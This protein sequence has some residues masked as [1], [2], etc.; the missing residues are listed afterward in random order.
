MITVTTK[1]EGNWLGL[2]RDLALLP[3]AL[4][5]SALW[6]QRKWGEKL[7][8]ILRGH[9]INQDLGWKE[10]KANHKAGDDRTLIDTETYLNSIKTWQK[11]FV[12]Y[13]G[14][15]RSAREPNGVSTEMVAAIHEYKSY[16]GGPYRALWSPSIEELGGVGAVREFVYLAILNKV[17]KMPELGK[18]IIPIK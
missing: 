14:V 3:P 5:S 18:Y 4:K 6:G 17:A 1:L 16:N 12:R 2:S 10:K 9:L 13:V 15:D 8:R 7:V 11:D